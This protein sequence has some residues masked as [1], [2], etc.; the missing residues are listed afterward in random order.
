MPLPQDLIGE[1]PVRQGAG[2]PQRS[3]HHGRHLAA[4][5]GVSGTE[6]QAGATPRP[7]RKL[8]SF[9]C[10]RVWSD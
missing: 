8:A 1:L 4:V 5:R 9:A 10:H 7:R 6:R 3:D 2:E